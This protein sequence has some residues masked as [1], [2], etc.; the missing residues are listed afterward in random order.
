VR[1]CGRRST[2]PLLSQEQLAARAELSERTL[3]NLEAGRV[4]SPCADTVRLLAGALQLRAPERESWLAAD[5]DLGPG[6]AAFF[7]RVAALEASRA[8]ISASTGVRSSYCSRPSS[9]RTVTWVPISRTGT[10]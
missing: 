2:G 8:V 1:C 10:Q 6:N 4:R 3:R 7:I 9:T 5:T